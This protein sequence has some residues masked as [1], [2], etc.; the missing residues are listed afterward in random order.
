LK[1]LG[2]VVIFGTY[3]FTIDMKKL[4]TL[5]IIATAL[6]G[7]Y[8]QDGAT[9]VLLNYN[10]VEKKVEKSNADIQDPSVQSGSLLFSHRA[11][12][13]HPVPGL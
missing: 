11:Y 8:A 10:T 2:K 13:F 3:K 1:V 5:A 9:V 7:M 12:P 6:T 4:V